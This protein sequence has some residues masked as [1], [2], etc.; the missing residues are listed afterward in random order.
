MLRGTWTDPCLR[1]EVLAAY[2]ERWI[3]ERPGLSE[4]SARYYRG[5]LRL[6]IAPELGPRD[7]RKIT[8]G[9]VRSWRQGLIATG[10][11]PSTVAKA[12]RL[13]RAVMATAV[14][15]EVIMRNPCRIRGA[16]VEAAA[17]RPVLSL[18]EVH[19]LAAAIEPRYRLLVLLARVRFVAVG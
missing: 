7:V 6:H 13:L 2:A 19:R 12:Y 18:P 14:D 10:V 15:D 5:L 1:G 11:G 8:P 16:G 17:E 3:C 9:M 4:R